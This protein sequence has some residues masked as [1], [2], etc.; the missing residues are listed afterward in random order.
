[1]QVDSLHWHSSGPT[2]LK[3]TPST[4]DFDRYIG[5]TLDG[6]YRLDRLLGRGGMGSVYLA[7]HLGTERVV[8]VKLITPRFMRDERFVERFKREA[9]AAGRLRHPNIV[10]VTDFGFAQ[11]DDKT[12]A[13]LVME[14]LDGCTLGNVLDE[15][16]RLPVAWVV[17]VMEQVCD[18]VQEAH[19]QGIIHRDLKPDNIWLEPNRLGGF[20]VKVL[21]F[22]IA[23]MADAD[24]VAE[25]EVTGGP[26]QIAVLADAQAETLLAETMADDDRESSINSTS[27]HRS[28]ARTDEN[29]TGSQGLD[30]PGSSTEISI[31]SDQLTRAGALLGTPLY[32]SPEQCRG[33]NLDAR[34][35]VYSLGVIAYSMLSGATPFEGPVAAVLRSHTEEDPAPLRERNR[36]LPRGINQ[37]VMSALDKDP[38]ARP[39]SAS[40]F[41]NALRANADSLGTLYRRAFALYSEH[42]PTVLKLSLLAHVP[43]FA[44]LMISIGL[45]LTGSPWAENMGQT[46][47]IAFGVLRGLATWGTTSCIAGAIAVMVAQLTATPL[48]PVRFRDAFAV[49]MRCWKPFVWTAVLVTIRVIPAMLLLVI[50]G[51]ILIRS[52]LFWAPVV[53]IEDLKGG[54]ALKRSANLAKRSRRDAT[55]AA[56]FQLGVPVL[57]ERW[58]EMLIGYDVRYRTGG[59]AEL[60]TQFASLVSILVS[61]LVSIVPALLYLKM[62]QFGGET[63]SD[64]ASPTDAAG[65]LRQWEKRMHDRLAANTP[66]K[67][68]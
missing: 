22:G 17:D 26:S 21:D 15:E 64:I 31:E 36:K 46:Q 66:R 62:R 51:L 65:S 54:A 52:Y 12:V 43:V 14:Y 29:H 60:V 49:L 34:S 67:T 30:T 44:V 16:K 45:R 3:A 2:E 6:K 38:S 39:Q 55:L 27:S 4:D 25:N 5:Q 32:M 48:R 57:M 9:R 35:D 18:A 24:G 63:V 56:L 41:A 33:G 20:R 28:E 7:V 58:L 23:K 68:F 37:V 42:F 10:D 50:P 19:R 59:S 13:Y 11:V 8:A 61:P 47:A 40:A 1:M 53:L